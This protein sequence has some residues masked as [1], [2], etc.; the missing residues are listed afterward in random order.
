MTEQ[1]DRRL[2]GRTKKIAQGTE[3]MVA[4][5]VARK[6]PSQNCRTCACATSATTVNVNEGR[7][8][9]RTITA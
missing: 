2:K 6:Q 9:K 7:I 8:S 5:E 1:K 3:I 4:I